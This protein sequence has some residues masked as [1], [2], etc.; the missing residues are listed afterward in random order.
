M[1]SG[2]ENEGSENVVNMETILPLEI[3]GSDVENPPQQVSSP[4]LSSS[5]EGKSV[6]AISVGSSARPLELSPS[7]GGRSP[8]SS[9]IAREYPNMFYCPISHQLLKDPVVMADGKSYERSA[10]MAK[11]NGAKASDEENVDEAAAE[12]ATPPS[13]AIAYSNRALKTI[14][15]ESTRTTLQKFQHTAKQLLVADG[16]NPR[17]LS[18]GFYCPITLGMMHVPVIDPQGYSYEKVAIENWIRVNGDSPVT[19]E[20][21]SIE[22]L[23]P[24]VAV[25]NLLLAEASKKD[26]MMHPAIRKWKNESP[27]VVP[28]MEATPPSA[29]STNDAAAIAAV[30]N[31]SNA[32]NREA[33]ITTPVV[34][35]PLTRE[36]F[37][38][39]Q[40]Q[41]ERTRLNRLYVRLGLAIAAI[42]IL[43]CGFYYPVVAAIALVLI[44]LGICMV[45][46]DAARSDNG[47]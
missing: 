45:T 37:Q 41:A 25:S 35:F 21:L 32:A 13:P 8:S 42:A 30:V 27:P 18:D 43:V 31:P 24:N 19:R 22:Q 10:A 1:D 14:I 20:S 12:N 6:P 4:T 26:E 7:S 16:T 9:S 28:L 2:K 44:I 11:L 3:Q 47:F 33:V 23:I 15:E 46:Q 36:E 29:L 17:P 39:R 40:R 38:I 34:S 5:G